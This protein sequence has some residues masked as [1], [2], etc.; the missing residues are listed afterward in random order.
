MREVYP[1]PRFPGSGARDAD[2]VDFDRVSGAVARRSIRVH[3][4]NAH[5]SRHGAGEGVHQGRPATGR[6]RPDRVVVLAVCRLPGELEILFA[7]R[8]LRLD[9]DLRRVLHTDGPLVLEPSDATRR[10][11]VGL[12]L[13]E[14]LAHTALA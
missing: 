13:S 2:E 12:L 1:R 10:T 6:D 5:R 11:A 3:H 4:A 9:H 8:V 7:R 14:H